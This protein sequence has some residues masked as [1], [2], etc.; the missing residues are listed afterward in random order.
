MPRDIPVG[1]GAV[2]VTFDK[3]YRIRDLYFPNVGKENHSQGSPFRFG[4]MADGRLAWVEDG[5]ELSLKYLRETLVTDVHGK[6]AGLQLAFDSN[7]LVDFHENLFLRRLTVH[8]LAASPRT[9]RVFFHHDFYISEVDV[10]DTA[11]YDPQL[12]ALI[13]Y[14]GPRYFLINVSGEGFRGV[15]EFATGLKGQPGKEG[16]WRDAEDGELQG[17]PI[18][19]GSVDSTLGVPLQIAA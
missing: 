1:N 8:N 3:S 9:I 5:W 12:K 16:T 6:H 13:H 10:G 17:H 18:A 2:L 7:D 11:L 19:Q 14:K 4:M 15:R